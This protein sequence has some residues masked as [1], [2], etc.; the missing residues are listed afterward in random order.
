MLGLI[1]F[2]FSQTLDV[3]FVFWG[4][5]YL[6]S[7]LLVIYMYDQSYRMNENRLLKDVVETKGSL[8]SRLRSKFQKYRLTLMYSNME[9][10]V[11]LFIIGP[12]LSYK[13]G[14]YMILYGMIAATLMLLAIFAIFF[15]LQCKVAYNEGKKKKH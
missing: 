8:L 12:L 9:T 13:Y 6:V 10:E 15:L 4:M 3:N 5:M 7:D 11:V 1:Y 14:I 2:T